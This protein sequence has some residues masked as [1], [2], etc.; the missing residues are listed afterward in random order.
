MSVAPVPPVAALRDVTKH[1][2]GVTA[3]DRVN[4][5]VAPGEIVAL[6]GDNG[7]GK[8]TLVKCIAGAHIPDSGTVEVAGRPVTFHHPSMARAM[9]IEAVYQELALADHLDVVANMFLG[10]E[11]YRRLGPLR[12]LDRVAMRKRASEITAEFGINIPSLRSSVRHLS[13]GQRQAV[14]I[15]RAVGWGSKL[16]IMDEPT[17][18]LGLRETARVEA[19]ISSLKARELGVLVISH[20][21]EQVLKLSDRIYVMRMGRVVAVK[22]TAETSGDEVVSLITGSSGAHGEAADPSR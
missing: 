7:A 18:A 10:R 8:S 16:V 3:L 15:G 17:A 11:I 22:V 21:L 2:G 4:L 9:G 1:F 20:N 19:L 12:V 14:A 5:E 6:V 13:G